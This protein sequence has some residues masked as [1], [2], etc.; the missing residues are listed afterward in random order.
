MALITLL[1]HAALPLEYQKTYIGHSDISIDNSLVKI[2][3]LE[4]LNNRKYDFI[5]SSDL[6]RCAQTLDLANISYE[7]DSR[8]RE[9]KFKKEM[10]LKNFKQVEMLESYNSKY[11]ETASTWHEYICEESLD[12]FRNRIK[13]FVDSLPKDKDILICSHAGAIRMLNSILTNYDYENSYLKIEYLDSIE[14]VL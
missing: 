12:E 10:E 6:K 5:Y 3:K 14:V 13:E 11:L 2:E 8:L 7:T 9:V 1:R 4:F